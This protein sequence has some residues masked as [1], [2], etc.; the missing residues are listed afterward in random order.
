MVSSLFNWHDLGHQAHFYIH[1][2][3]ILNRQQY[4]I[5]TNRGIALTS[6]HRIAASALLFSDFFFPVKVKKL[7]ICAT[8]AK[9]IFFSIL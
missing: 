7:I 8:F 4:I 3:N 6:R 5:F 1:P 2:H 9:Y